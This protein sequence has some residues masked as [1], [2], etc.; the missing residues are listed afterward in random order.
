MT[1]R[2]QNV[3]CRFFFGRNLYCK[4]GDQCQFSHVDQDFKNSGFVKCP[5]IG[6][7]NVCKGKQCYQCHKRMK[8]EKFLA[9]PLKKCETSSCNQETRHRLC[10]SCHYGSNI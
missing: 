6:C 9:R 4:Y 3:P 10:R 8:K 2:G 1:D 5:N 7:N